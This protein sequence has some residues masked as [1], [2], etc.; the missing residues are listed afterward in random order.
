MI[1]LLKINEKPIIKI[2]RNFNSNSVNEANTNTEYDTTQ[3]IK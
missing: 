2:N 1:N 3:G